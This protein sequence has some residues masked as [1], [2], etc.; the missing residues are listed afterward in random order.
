MVLLPGGW[1]CGDF[2]T[3]NYISFVPRC[4]GVAHQLPQV[5][6]RLGEDDYRLAVFGF[7][8]SREYHP[9]PLFSEELLG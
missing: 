9:K 6:E 1:G 4:Q 7:G 2:M 8:D 3:R 5:L